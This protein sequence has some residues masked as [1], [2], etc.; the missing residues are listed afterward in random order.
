MNII[1]QASVVFGA[2]LR[3]L[4]TATRRSCISSFNRAQGFLAAHPDFNNP[5]DLEDFASFIINASPDTQLIEQIIADDSA[6]E[7]RARSF[8]SQ[9]VGAKRPL[10]AEP[11]ISNILNA[12]MGLLF[13][14]MIWHDGEQWM[15]KRGEEGCVLFDQQEKQQIYQSPVTFHNHLISPF[16]SSRDLMI[17][18]G[19]IGLIALHPGEGSTV[20]SLSMYVTPR[21]NPTTCMPFRDHF[22]KCSAIE[23]LF[24]MKVQETLLERIGFEGEDEADLKEQLGGTLDNIAIN[25]LKILKVPFYM[26][27]ELSASDRLLRLTDF[28]DSMKEKCQTF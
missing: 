9:P 19:E 13:E 16:P 12:T 21:V 3:G 11:R 26:T 4:D 7:L 20:S 2:K 14:I 25:F 6:L 5:D 24:R 22:E 10:L 17:R 23:Y 28:V 15:V 27:Y 8:I 18:S 1:D